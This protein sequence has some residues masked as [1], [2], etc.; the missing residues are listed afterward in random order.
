MVNEDTPAPS[1]NAFAIYSDD[2]KSLNFYNDRRGFGLVVGQQFEGKTV[3]AIYE[4]FEIEDYSSD[5]TTVPWYDKRRIIETVQVVDNI[6]P[7]STAYWFNDFEVCSSIQLE[8]LN[9]SNITNMKSMFQ[10]CFVLTS[11]TYQNFNVSKVTNMNSMFSGCDK[12]ITFDFSKW[13]TSSLKTATNMFAGCDALISIDL[14]NFNTSKL[15]NTGAMFYNCKTLTSINLSNWDTTSFKTMDGMF[16]SCSQLKKIVLSDKF[17]WIGDAGFLPA[18]GEDGLWYAESDGVGYTS[19]NIPSNKADTYYSN[20]RMIQRDMSRVKFYSDTKAKIDSK[21]VENGA[22]YV[23]KDVGELY[24]DFDGKRIA[25]GKKPPLATV[26]NPGIVKPDGST[27]LIDEQGT[28]SVSGDSKQK[29]WHDTRTPGEFYKSTENPT[30]T[31]VG[32][33][34][35]YLYATR[36]YNAVWN[37]YAELFEAKEK[38]E[39]GFIAYASPEGVTKTGLPQ[40]AVGVVSDRWGHLLGGDGKHDS[41]NYVPISLAGRI[42]I[43]VNEK[44]KIGDM[45]AATSDGT[46]KKATS[47]DFGCILG[48]C[49]GPDPD[50]RE[51]FVYM[52]V[53]VM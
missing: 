50:G 25:I 42:P 38:V 32:K 15:E 20:K 9:T 7:I 49:V 44:I 19:A 46:G 39:T 13:S 52:L 48:K 21:S 12:L 23:A 53:G 2:D 5:Y 33:Y 36:V 8:K 45:I 14:S 6:A 1:S 35:G 3:T 30:S 24:V 28:I 29:I 17:A 47:E 40:C 16:D 43:K 11:L 26:E 27:I 37:D 22:L 34:D 31:E 51:D 4:N 41:E 10:S 18:N